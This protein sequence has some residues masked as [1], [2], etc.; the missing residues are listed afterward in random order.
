VAAR[1]AY[2]AVA[3]GAVEVALVLGVE[4]VTDKDSGQV[5]A[6]L[7]TASDADYE[8]IQGVTAGAQAALLMRRYLY[9]HQ[10]PQDALAGFSLVAHQN[11][12]ANPNAMFRNEISLEQYSKAPMVSDPLN[13]YDAAPMADGAAALV[14]TR[15]ETLQNAEARPAVEIAGS[16]V[17]TAAMSVHDLLD[18]LGLPAAAAV[19]LRGM[20]AA[21]RLQ[22]Q[23]TRLELLKALLVAVNRLRLRLHFRAQFLQ[24]QAARQ[25]AGAV[26][27]GAWIARPAAAAPDGVARNDR[28][29][30]DQPR[31][32]VHRFVVRGRQVNAGQQFHHHC[33][34]FHFRC[35]AVGRWMRATGLFVHQGHSGFWRCRKL[36]QPRGESREQRRLK[37]T[38][39]YML[40]RRLPAALDLEH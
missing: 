23:K 4:K 25:H 31:N 34:P 38:V 15:A 36:R 39:Q 5:E 2:L 17:A 20:V 28:L 1:Q 29:S 14:L 22:R 16:A 32:A 9:E 13:T 35:Q 7:A 6:A 37:Q 27:V 33:G 10:A 26:L 40:D 30:R 8:A 21:L 24:Q 18:P 12:V 19:E 11:A 3:S